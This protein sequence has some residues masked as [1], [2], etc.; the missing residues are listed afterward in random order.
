MAVIDFDAATF[1]PG[2]TGRL[3]EVWDELAPDER[4]ALRPHLWGDTSAEWIA[5]TLT[6]HGHS[7]GAT[8]I[9]KFRRLVK[10]GVQSGQPH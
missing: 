2:M 3:A 6:Q 1:H 10:G 5:Q 7:I 9:K 4:D 8:T